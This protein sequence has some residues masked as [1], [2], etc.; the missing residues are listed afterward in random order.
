MLELLPNRSY[1]SITTKAQRL[2]LKTREFWSEEEIEIMNK[3]YHLNTPAEMMKLL[4][5]R[6]RNSIIDCAVKLHLVSSFKYSKEESQF[7]IDN[8]KTMSDEEMERYLH[9]LPRSVKGKRLSLGL[10]RT[11]EESSYN[12]LSEYVRKNN[13]EWKAKSMI[14][15]GYKC[16]LTG[17]R[18][19]DI[20]HIYGLNLILNET[21]NE[22]HIAIKESIND[23][24]DKELKNIL[25]N[26]RLKQ[27]EYPVGVCLSKNVHML[28]HNTYGYGNNTQDQWDEFVKDFRKGKYNEILN[29]S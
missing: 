19:D 10:F 25:D 24:T 1:G 21:L 16:V 13:L 9:K 4:P 12:D 2:N 5:N 18:F 15:C 11:K 3:Y 6:S 14:H 29:V 27:S 23:Y 22:L 8:W 7:I 26:F 17:K 28:F 20:H